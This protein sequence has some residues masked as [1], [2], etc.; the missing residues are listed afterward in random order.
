MQLT[1]NNRWKSKSVINKLNNNLVEPYKDI[2]YKV[3]HLKLKEELYED[4]TYIDAARQLEKK[5]QKKK[6]IK[7][8]CLRY[9][10]YLTTF[11]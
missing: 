1:L 4:I 7:F 6:S 8:F 10:F 5:T 2:A 3:M 11:N 9:Y